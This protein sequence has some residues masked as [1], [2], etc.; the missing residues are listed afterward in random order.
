MSERPYDPGLQ[1]ERTVLAW[2]RTSLSLGAGALVYSRVIA[3]A[4]GDWAW[5]FAL[6]G[7]AVSLTI[8]IWARRRYAY[9]HRT[10]TGG[11]SQLADGLMPAVVA[12]T[13]SVAG[14]A[15]LVVFLVAL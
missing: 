1:P 8:G 10:L 3:P 12:A 7:L 9:T 4:V 5:V 15:A 11:G 2:Q 14:I 6:F 13:V